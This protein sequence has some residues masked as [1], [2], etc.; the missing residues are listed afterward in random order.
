[1]KEN[2]EDGIANGWTPSGGTWSIVPDTAMGNQA[3]RQS[4]TSAGAFSV[5]VPEFAGTTDY[6]LQVR[7]KVNAFGSNGSVQ[8]FARYTDPGN[9]YYMLANGAQPTPQVQLKKKYLGVTTTLQIVSFT[10]DPGVW[11]ALRL[12][13]D[14]TSIK[15][16]ID[17]SLVVSATDPDL[18]SGQPR[19]A[20]NNVDVKF[21]DVVVSLADGFQDGNANGWLTSGGTWSVMTDGSSVLT[22]SD[23]AAPQFYAYRGSPNWTNYGIES[24]MKVLTFGSSGSAMLRTRFTDA[25]NYYY[26]LL[27]GTQVILKKKDGGLT[28]TLSNQPFTANPGTWYKVKLVANGANLEAWIDGIRVISVIDSAPLANGFAALAGHNVDVR[29]DD[30]VVE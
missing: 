13:V 3:L 6:A 23:S 16:Y 24:R 18:T 10:M 27:N 12:Q 22:Q 20:G 26:L 8:M 30:V 19:L 1:L 14:G 29:F 5:S 28:T 7:T 4:S 17:D 25:N 9:Y 21:D 2:F 15:G 11:H